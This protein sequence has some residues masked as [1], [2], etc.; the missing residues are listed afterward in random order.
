MELQNYGKKKESPETSVDNIFFQLQI[1]KTMKTYAVAVIA[2]ET[3]DLPAVIKF[4]KHINNQLEKMKTKGQISDS[5]LESY[6]ERD[7]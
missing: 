1:P 6:H 3:D 5:L 2:W 7:K 4:A